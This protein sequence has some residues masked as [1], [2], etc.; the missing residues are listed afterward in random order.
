V[1]DEQIRLYAIA[2]VVVPVDSG[3]RVFREATSGGSSIYTIETRP[4]D[5]RRRW[6]AI[7]GRALRVGFPESVVE[8]EIRKAVG[9][10]PA[11]PSL[12]A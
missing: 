5:G 1:T 11:S 6:F 9:R 7:H 4:P 3:L 10:P 2:R 8:D 12:P